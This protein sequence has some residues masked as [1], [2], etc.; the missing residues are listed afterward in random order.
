M[1]E[2]FWKIKYM[3]CRQS[4]NPWFNYFPVMGK[5]GIANRAQRSWFYLPEKCLVGESCHK[6]LKRSSTLDMS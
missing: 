4:I 5:N 1:F 3:A 2:L 6:I